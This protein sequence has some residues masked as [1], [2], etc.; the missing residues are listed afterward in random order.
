MQEKNCL[1]GEEKKEIK[2]PSDVAL[3][4]N[5]KHLTSC[6]WAV[7]NKRFPLDVEVQIING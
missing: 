5:G 7:N 1:L 2:E 6:I 4:S 3:E